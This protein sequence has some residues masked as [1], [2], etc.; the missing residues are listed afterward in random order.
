MNH[1]GPQFSFLTALGFFF[2]SLLAST[3][4][5]SECCSHEG[6]GQTSQLSTPNFN[7]PVQG[8]HKRH[9]LTLVKST[10]TLPWR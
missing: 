9:Y 7:Y 1:S 10:S 8:Q 3:V 2:G 4:N 5:Y 6:L